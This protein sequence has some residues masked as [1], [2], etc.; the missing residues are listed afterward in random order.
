[1][2][3]KGHKVIL[4]LLFINA[5]VF[6]VKA[7]TV[8]EYPQ[9]L[10]TKV[11][12]VPKMELISIP[13]H[14]PISPVQKRE[15]DKVVRKNKQVVKANEKIEQ[16]LEDTYPFKFEMISLDELNKK[17]NTVF[18]L[19]S[20]SQLTKKMAYYYKDNIDMLDELMDESENRPHH[21]K[22]VY[23]YYYITLNKTEKEF[24]MVDFGKKNIPQ[25]LRYFSKSVE[26]CFESL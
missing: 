6:S 1:M 8:F 11:L 10:K 7:Q 17:D 21:F 2:I 9:A 16:I 22:D 26:A 3:Y 13:T 4:F 15:Y 18:V 19:E 14:S 24:I 25:A 5:C 20:F 23:L 12:Y